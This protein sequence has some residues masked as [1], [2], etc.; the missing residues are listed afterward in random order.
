M[1]ALRY[2]MISPTHA[3]Q[4]LIANYCMGTILACSNYYVYLE[5]VFLSTCWLVEHIDARQVH[6]TGLAVETKGTMEAEV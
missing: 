5:S 6:E 2:A 4:Q 1:V 3:Y